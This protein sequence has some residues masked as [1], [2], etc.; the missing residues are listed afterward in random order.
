MGLTATLGADEAARASRI[1][2]SAR[3]GPTLTTGFEG[4]N[5]TASA[6]R[7]PE[8]GLRGAGVLDA[9]QLDA[10]HLVPLAPAHE[11]LLELEEAQP[12]SLAR[13]RPLSSLMGKMT[14]RTPRELESEPV[15]VVSVWP[16]CRRAV[17]STWVARSRSPSINQVS[18][19]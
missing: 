1:P 14:L 19:P 10:E 17:L 11:V 13:S 12:V 9:A 2:G 6:A 16:A 5:T 4:Q 15:M 7:R 3:I 8:D 18:S